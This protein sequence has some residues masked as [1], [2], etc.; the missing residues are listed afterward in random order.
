MQFFVAYLINSSLDYYWAVFVGAF[1]IYAV[2]GN[3]L[4][5][6]IELVL[7]EKIQPQ[8]TLST[9]IISIL[10]YSLAGI[11]VF[12][13][14]LFVQGSFLEVSLSQLM[15]LGVVPALIYYINSL[16]IK[17]FVV[18]ISKWRFA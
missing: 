6:L 17:V 16:L 4:S 13:T 2:L 12:L 1:V 11:V 9:F 18:K 7:L 14:V 10:L 5:Y 3:T 15:V 8:S